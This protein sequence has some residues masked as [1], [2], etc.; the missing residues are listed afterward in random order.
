MCII[1][2]KPLNVDDFTT[3][4][5]K[6]CW[7][8]NDDGAGFAYW[9]DEKQ[10]WAVEKGFLTFKKFIKAYQAHNFG[11][12]DVS[13]VHFRIGTSGLKDKGNTH[14]FQICDDYEKMREKKFESTA[15]AFHNGVV[16]KGEGNYSDTMVHIADYLFPIFPLWDDK[17]INEHIAD[18][19]LTKNGS[20]W[21]VCIKDIYYYYGTF[22][23]YKG[24]KFSNSNYK[25]YEAPAY[26]YAGYSQVYSPSKRDY[27]VKD[28]DFH[29][30]KANKDYPIGTW[31]HGSV[32]GVE[33]FWRGGVF[34]KWSDYLKSRRSLQVQDPVQVQPIKSPGEF[35]Q[36]YFVTYGTKRGKCTS[37]IN[38]RV[39]SQDM[40]IQRKNRDK[41]LAKAAKDMQLPPEKVMTGIVDDDGS[42]AWGDGKTETAM[43]QELMEYKMCPSC[44][45]ETALAPTPFTLG[46][47]LCLV[48]GC[49]FTLATGEIHTYDVDIHNKFNSRVA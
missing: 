34:T 2:V 6:Y 7:E 31:T 1:A 44:F 39:F 23:E 35:F 32:D 47:S 14:P 13:I 18:A 24:W 25:P 43:N 30:I 8:K 4:I 29:I 15:I 41:D 33:G 49:V 40:H 27:D 10:V 42:L 11:K 3:D 16:G 45:E 17:R 22:H 38:W 28:P 48:C 37:I 9:N 46:D 36:R 19:L 21:L 26:N 12:E 5:L 20:R